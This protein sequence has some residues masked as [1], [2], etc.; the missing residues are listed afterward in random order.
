MKAL[1]IEDP[2]C[3]TRVS[4]YVPEIVKFVEKIIENGYAY[5]SNGSGTEIIFIIFKHDFKFI[6]L[7]PTTMQKKIITTPNSFPKLSAIKKPLRLVLPRVRV[8]SLVIINRKND[9]ILILHCGKRRNQANRHGIHHG[10]EVAP[11]GILNAQ[12]LTKY[13]SHHDF[14]VF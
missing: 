4:E 6:S 10:V 1:N 13:D 14:R 12:V 7:Y 8:A 5:E 3:L 2:D 11:A 9:L